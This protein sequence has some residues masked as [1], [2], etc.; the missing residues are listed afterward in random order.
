L[1]KCPFG[2]ISIW[3]NVRSLKFHR[4]ITLFHIS[5]VPTTYLANISLADWLLANCNSFRRTDETSDYFLT[6]RWQAIS[7]FRKLDR[8]DLEVDWVDQT[9]ELIPQD[10]VRF[11]QETIRWGNFEVWQV[12]LSC[13]CPLFNITFASTYWCTFCKAI[14]Q[15]FYRNWQ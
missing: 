8:L 10:K 15:L 1:V 12:A 11:R 3:W 6:W 9:D 7:P 2:E 14:W 4:T 13:L 5:I